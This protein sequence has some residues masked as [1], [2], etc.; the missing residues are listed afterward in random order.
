[1]MNRKKYL[2]MEI[3]FTQAMAKSEELYKQKLYANK[4][5]NRL[6]REKSYVLSPFTY[7]LIMLY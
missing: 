6:L 5:F 4:V 2:K 1:M 7:V 3:Q